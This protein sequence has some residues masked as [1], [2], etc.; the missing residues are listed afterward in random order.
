M[1]TIDER[2]AQRALWFPLRLSL[3]W[4]IGTYVAFLVV[5]EVELVENLWGLSWYVAF[6]IACFTI[7]YCVSIARYRR[8]IPSAVPEPDE[9]EASQVRLLVSL[10]ALYYVAYGITYL[11]QYGMLGVSAIAEALRNPGAAYISKFAIVETL[12]ATSAA[13]QAVTLASVL[14]APLVPFLIVYWNRLTGPMRLF[15]IGAVVTYAL[16]FLSIGTLVGLGNVVVYAAAGILVTQAR[17]VAAPG[18]KR[19]TVLVLGI[20]A[21]FGF[22]A[23]MS[24]NQGS[25]IQAVGVKD[26]YQP[27]PI[28]QSLTNEQFARGVAVTAFYPTHGYQ[29]LAYNLETPFEWT[30]GRGASR[31]L[32]SYMAQYGGVDSVADR[33]Y[34]AR[35][36]L[37]TGW[38][39][40]MYWAT[41]YPWLASDLGF[42]GAALFMGV[43]GWWMARWWYESAF[44]GSRL[45]LLLL[46]QMLLLV[47]F[48]PANF[49]LGL[50]RGNLICI[51][52]LLA[53]YFLTKKPPIPKGGSSREAALPATQLRD[54][55]NLPGDS[56]GQGRR[57][58]RSA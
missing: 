31:A 49:Q 36:E 40:G 43:V 8:A 33:T 26:R 2:R 41:I 9:R 37:R 7:G 53:L 58:S 35:T 38:P 39:A 42:T 24:Y 47:A 51:T 5:G 19:R 20:I 6:T 1:P 23:Y 21:A 16:F 4:L 12:P 14:H 11:H 10:S 56:G 54:G 15:A 25:R 29:G 28:V 45:A 27:N 34:P 57:L 13:A 52:M 17:H 30:G 46:A 18:R 32:D 44:L 48:V 3:W 50:S 22:A 55:V